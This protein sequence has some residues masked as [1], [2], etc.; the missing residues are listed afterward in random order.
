MFKVGDH[1][2]YGTNGVC[3]V[4][5]ITPSPF[6]KND[7]RTYY[8]LKPLSGASTS[9]IY[10]PV[11]NEH[12]PMRPLL[13]RKEVEALLD[14][15]GSIPC[16]T[17]SEERARKLTYR[18]AIAAAEPQAYISLIKTVEGRRADFCG[19]QRRLPDFEIEYDA[20]ARRHLCTELS[21]VLDRPLSDVFAYISECFSLA[22]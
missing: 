20:L 17:V 4:S 18:N 19:T 3:L 12:V 10:T 2:V 8:V 5:D 9:L 6:D 16:L 1:V 7:R 21:V 22:Q 13:A 15:I 11:D 14:G